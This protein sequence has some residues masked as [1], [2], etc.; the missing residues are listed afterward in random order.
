M[1][2]PCRSRPRPRCRRGPFLAVLRSPREPRRQTTA[3]ELPLA[4]SPPCTGSRR[5]AATVA[6]RRPP[7]NRW[8]DHS[9]SIA[10]GEVQSRAWAPSPDPGKQGILNGCLSL[11]APRRRCRYSDP[12]CQSN[13]PARAAQRRCCCPTLLIDRQALALNRPVA[14]VAPGEDAVRLLSALQQNEDY[15]LGAR[16]AAIVEPDLHPDP[17]GRARL[18]AS[19]GA[20]G[21]QDL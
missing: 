1:A 2:G 14:V 18:V 21:V 8:Q 19:R 9:A 7:A 15:D 3:R 10:L 17:G 13:V 4:R 6:S 11:Y 16:G 12:L 20:R 5:T